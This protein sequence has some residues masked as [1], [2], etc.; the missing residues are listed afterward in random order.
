[1]KIVK[2]ELNLAKN[3]VKTSVLVNFDF[4][5]HIIRKKAKNYAYKYRRE[6]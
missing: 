1:M 3:G 6:A 2:N 5:I 4:W